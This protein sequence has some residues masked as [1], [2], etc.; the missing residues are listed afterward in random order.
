MILRTLPERI[1]LR[2]VLVFEYS[3]V[4]LVSD[5]LCFSAWASQPPVTSLV[6]E[7]RRWLTNSLFGTSHQQCGLS[8]YLAR[9]PGKEVARSFQN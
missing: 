6:W 3:P 2:T 1:D 9:G 7:D 5:D 8:V 4:S